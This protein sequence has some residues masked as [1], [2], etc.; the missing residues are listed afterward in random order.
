MEKVIL[1]IL[2]FLLIGCS[3]KNLVP[4]VEPSENK[5]YNS[6]IEVNYCFLNISENK[7]RDYIGNNKLYIFKGIHN[8]YWQYYLYADYTM[9]TYG[10]IESNQIDE[11]LKE[12]ENFIKWSH[13]PEEERIL[14][15]DEYEKTITLGV[16][17][18]KYFINNGKPYISQVLID[19][20]LF[21]LLK[22]ERRYFV[23]V[24]TA[25][26][27]YIQLLSWK[28]SMNDATMK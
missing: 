28:A 13:L 9:F 24:T 27:I 23:D 4:I 17:G 5:S 14:K 10:K 2:A 8:D 26:K 21:G 3:S 12:I 11:A 15:Q 19:N 6:G 22:Y 25:K 1:F 16:I 7:C 18:R 20:S